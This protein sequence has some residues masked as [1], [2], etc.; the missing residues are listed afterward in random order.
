METVRCGR[1]SMVQYSIFDKRYVHL[2]GKCWNCFKE[3]LDA[4]EMAEE[5]FD[6]QANAAIE[7]STQSPPL[8]P[9][10]E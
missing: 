7:L 4:G 6:E 3:M 8:S 1:C 5:K 2:F 9:G 10:E